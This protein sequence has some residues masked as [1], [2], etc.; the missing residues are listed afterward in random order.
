MAVS[1]SSLASEIASALGHP[2]DVTQEVLGWATGVLNE[3]TQ[4]GIATFGGGTPTG[5]TI[6]GMTGASMASRV[7]SAAGYPSISTEL[8]N[9][10][11]AIASYVQ[12]NTI[13]TY[14][15]PPPPA[16]PNYFQNGTISGLVGSGLANAVQASVGYPFVS[17]PLLAKCSA[18]TS[19]IMTNAQVQLGVIS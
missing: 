1:I 19:H 2:G 9:F 13:V 4:S 15:G 16:N 10:C 5:H 11:T 7:A 12:G 8:L 17:S 3:L 6:S 18:I 14:T